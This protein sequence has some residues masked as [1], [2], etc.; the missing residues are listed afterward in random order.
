VQSQN[1]E[2][3]CQSQDCTLLGLHN[4]DIAEHQCAI[5]RLIVREREWLACKRM[6]L[7]NW[8]SLMNGQL[9]VGNWSA[10]QR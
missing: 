2:T 10:K 4:L 5:S 7:A 8:Q 6:T 3:A 9:S 1:P